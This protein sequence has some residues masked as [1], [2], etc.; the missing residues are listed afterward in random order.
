MLKTDLPELTPMEYGAA[1]CLRTEC[2]KALEYAQMFPNSAAPILAFLSGV[3]DMS[4]YTL[5][6]NTVAPAITG[7]AQVGV[8]LTADEGTWTGIPTPTLTLQ[9]FA[10]GVAIAGATASTYDPVAGDI[11]AVITVRVTATNVRGTVSVTSAPT[12]AVVA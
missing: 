2:W 8:T 5:P 4:T 6:A 9:W 11:G 10:D 12:A 7:T 1:N 3:A